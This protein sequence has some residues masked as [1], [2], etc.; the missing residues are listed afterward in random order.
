MD[1][2]CVKICM[3]YTEPCT[4]NWKRLE[5]WRPRV[6]FSA[7]TPTILIED[8]RFPQS[9]QENA[10]II[11][12]SNCFLVHLLQFITIASMSSIFFMYHYF[13]REKTCRPRVRTE[14]NERHTVVEVTSDRF[15]TELNLP[16]KLGVELQSIPT[17]MPSPSR[18]YL[19]CF[20]LKP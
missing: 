4:R 3:Y 1:T 6:W 5:F 8:F 20:A 2:L 12:Y 18:L 10:A 15:E 19:V 11:L 13:V 9:L 14:V 17:N 16:V 7:R